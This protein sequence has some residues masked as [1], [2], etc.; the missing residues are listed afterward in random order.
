MKRAE[1][2]ESPPIS[3]GS[4]YLIFLKIAG[5]TLGG[6]AVMLPL[7]EEEFVK[8]R[9]RLSHEEMTDIFFL[10]N[11]LPGV[12]AINSS[13]L[14]GRSLRG[15]P[16]AVV[17]VLG[18]LTPSVGIILLIAQG[19]GLISGHPLVS[20][21]FSGVRAGVTALL[22]LVLINMARR[23]FKNYKEIII[24]AGTVVLIRWAGVNPVLVI[25]LAAAAGF[26]AFRGGEEK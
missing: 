9:K 12:I 14:I 24:A 8:R 20:A 5:L 17:S 16:G 7:M 11:T 1:R 10:T 19:I 22:L 15:L 6:G 3:L 2:A 23:N 26:L 4:L 13:L 21:A 25:L 18:V